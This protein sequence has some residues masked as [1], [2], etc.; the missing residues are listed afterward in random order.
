MV[1]SA[2]S[3]V[4]N[5]E[6]PVRRD[7]VKV[8]G[9]QNETTVIRFKADNPGPWFIHCHIDWHLTAGFA[10]VMAED[11][12]ETPLKDPT[13]RACILSVDDLLCILLNFPWFTAA[14][15]DLCPVWDQTI[16]LP[17]G[18]VNASAF[19]P[20]KVVAAP[21]TTLD[22]ASSVTLLPSSVSVYSGT[23]TFSATQSV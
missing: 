16:T 23:P 1:R 5:Y 6:N 19:A 9:F 12:R 11:V 22:L 13:S 20:I 10:A 4:Y 15:R 18:T 7:V 8:G 3:S 21:S 17:N 14:W 2:G